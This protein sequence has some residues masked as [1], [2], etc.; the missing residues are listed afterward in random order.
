MKKTILSFA[1][2]LVLILSSA[3]FLPYIFKDQIVETVRNEA[4]KKL[5]ATL[6]FDTNIG[7]NIF[8]SFPNLNLSLKDVSLCYGSGIYTNDTLFYARKIEVS[9]DLMQ[10]YKKQQYVFGS[11]LLDEPLIHLEATSDSMVN[12]DVSFTQDTSTSGTVINFELSKIQITNGSFRYLDALSKT[13]VHLRGIDHTSSG[14]FNSESFLLNAKTDITKIVMAYDGN[15]FINGWKIHQLG[16]IAV[17]LVNSKYALDKNTLTINGLDA[18]L[19]GFIQLN[20]DNMIFDLGVNSKTPDLNKFLTL[21]PAIYASDFGAMQT[22]GSGTLS[23]KFKGVYSEKSFPAYDV[24]M[25]IDRG[26]FKYPELPMPMEDIDLKLHIYSKDGNTDRT[27]IDLQKMHFKM[28]NDP[29][30][31]RLNMQHIFG[32]TLLDAN[33]QGKIDLANV[34]KIVPLNDTELSGLLDAKIAVK[35][36]VNDITAAAV[37]KFQASGTVEAQNVIYKTAKMSKVLNIEKATISV[38][39]QRLDIPVFKGMIGKNDINFSGKFD[40]FF[41]YVLNDQTL[42]GNATLSS[43]N[44]NTNDFITEGESNDE[45][46]EMTLVEVPGNVSITLTTTIDKLTYDNLELT[47]FSGIMGIENST[48][49]L[50][51]VSTD[52][53]GGRVNLD[54]SYTYDTKKPVAAFDF[55]YTNIK[56][57]DLVNKF[58]FIKVFAPIAES[59]QAMTTAKLTMATELNNDMSPK[60]ES[61]NLGG[62]INLK[63]LVLGHVEALQSIDTK[64]GTNHFGVNKLRDFLVDFSIQD[65]KLFV[66]PFDVFID[67]AKIAL[68]GVS[69]LDGS[70][71]YK[72]ILSLPSS[73]IKNEVSI[74]NN[75]T[76][77]TKFSNIQLKPNDFL[78]IAIRIQGNF[79]KPTV[80]LNINEIKNT[81]KQTAKNSVI[82]TI[83][84]QKEAATKQALDAVNKLKDETQKKA[85]EEREKIRVELKQRQ[86]EAE[87]RVQQETDKKKEE[88][89]KKAGD[90]IKGLFKK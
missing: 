33:I 44:L 23:A 2:L 1:I 46:I 19:T 37:D 29:F 51:K 67:S 66:S 72:G 75:L 52:L 26:Y 20:E 88:L 45:D 38:Q 11:I 79:K 13:D 78:D 16:E 6:H 7:I 28:A 31:L 68:Q 54:A 21:V 89:K 73:Y 42:R 82:N 41:A 50:Q 69:K 76:A 48:V 70:I 84:V 47:N 87:E 40:N 74:V 53:L 57:A 18:N 81:M 14:N 5:K 24:S 55:S 90:K 22:K 62:S 63:N 10:F 43:K 49:K 36:K 65:G 3:I 8:K 25:Q 17:D 4:N 80:Q 83:E 59:I 39:N 30:D 86:K 71:D 34:V 27:V 64:L 9:F 61:I 15:T 58:T 56:I 35:G 32:N 12:W 60:L 85:D 77:G